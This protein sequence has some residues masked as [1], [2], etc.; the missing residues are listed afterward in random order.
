MKILRTE[1]GAM[2]IHAHEMATDAAEA[3]GI[4]A[5]ADVQFHQ[6]GASIICLDEDSDRLYESIG[7]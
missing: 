6:Y 4:A 5:A 7:S 1:S 3:M 2:N